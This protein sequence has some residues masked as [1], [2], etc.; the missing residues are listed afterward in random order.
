MLVHMNKNV[1]TSFITDALDTSVRPQDDFFRFVNGTWLKNAVIPDD[2][3]STGS[4]IDLHVQAEHDVHDIITELTNNS[5][6]TSQDARNIAALYSSWMDIDTINNNGYSPI[7]GEE[8]KIASTHTHKELAECIGSMMR[9][10]V[11]TFFSFDIDSNLNNPHEYIAYFGQSGLGLP[12]EA[13]YHEDQ[14]KQILNEYEKFLPQIWQLIYPDDD[15]TTAAHEVIEFEKQLAH[16]HVNIVEGRDANKKNNPM[17]LD[18]FIE[19]SPGFDW[20]S[21]LQAAGIDTDKIA[22]ILVLHPQ[23]LSASAHIWGSTSLATLKNYQKWRLARARASYLSENID[24]RMFE[25]Y[26]TILS[27]TPTQ[28]ERWKRGVSLINGSLGEAVG[29][30]Y[31][32]RHFPATHK[33]YMNQLVDDLLNAYAS[34]ISSLDWMSEKTKKQAAKKVESFVTKIGYPDVWRDYSSLTLDT[35]IVENIRCINAFEFDYELAKLG[36]SVNRNE[37]FMTP[38]TVNAYYNPTWNEIVFPAAILQLPF[39]DPTRDDAFNYGGIGAVIGH[40]IGHGFDDQGSKYDETGKLHNWWT[41]EDRSAFEQR[42]HALIAQYDAYIPQDLKESGEHVQGALTIGENIGDLGGLTIALK[43]YEISLERQGYTLE[44]A[45]SYDGYTATQRFFLSWARI[46]REKRRIEYMRTLIAVDPHS[47]AEF[48]CN[49]VLKNC[50]AF[51]N[52]FHLSPADELYLPPE[53]RVHIW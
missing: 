34:S 16:T 21:C 20:L 31:V 17:K 26:G 53:E 30:I 15:A 42:T 6:N 3:S 32:E 44:T 22:D 12:D 8:D 43:A 33:E 18:T 1:G 35:D 27:G 11:G 7:K 2:L 52:A 28:K 49:G 39:F 24:T 13:Y 51:V 40:E 48:R 23:T 45:P 36:I 14:Y 9:E 25:F 5:K 38:Q 10:G 46:W 41:E 50:D 19:K 4:F 29:K 37:W 47:P